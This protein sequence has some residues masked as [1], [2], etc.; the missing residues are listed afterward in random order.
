VQREQARSRRWGL[1]IAAA[2]LAA[3]VALPQT[4]GAVLSGVNG[5]IVFVSGR[6]AAA[7]NDNTS[8]LFLRPALGS[9]GAGT[10]SPVLTATGAGQHR[11]PT[12]SPDRTRIAYAEGDPG[13]MGASNFDIFILDLTNPSATPQNITNSNNVTDDRPAWSPDGTTIAF[14]SENADPGANDPP[15]QLN[16][17]LYNVG[18]GATSDFT[19]T[20]AGTYEHK[21]AWTPDSQTLFYGDGNPSTTTLNDMDILFQPV[22]GGGATQVTVEGGMSEF[23]P[24]IS[25][26]GTRMCFTRGDLGDGNARVV[27]SLTNGGGQTVL[28]GNTAAG[29]AGYNCTWSPDGTKIAYVLGVF[30]TGDLWIEDSNLSGANFLPLESTSMHFDGNP[31]WAPDGRPSCKDATV[32]TL[33]G[34]SVGVPVSCP[35]SG[36]AYEQTSVRAVL[37]TEPL[38][39]TVSPSKQDPAVL[40]PTNFTYTPNAGFIGTDQFKVRSLDEVAFGDRDGTMTVKVALPCANRTPTVVG[41]DGSDQLVGTGGKDVISALGGND[42]VKALGGNDVVCGGP[43]KDTLKGGGGKDKLLGQGGKDSLKGGGGKDTCKGGKGGDTASA[44][45]VRKS[46]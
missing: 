16:I 37:Q 10:A 9:I 33:P 29:I 20:A 28:P 14:E 38:H 25:P 34:K 8:K 40:L 5:R 26:D 39:G 23:Q 42:K 31:D 1:L 30:T 11:H 15:A 6:G 2:C 35:D 43:G 36:P 22:A 24:S 32:I 18:S 13:A 46:I 44:C 12:W 7:G 17:K 3:A 41:T 19:S 27:V 4:A 45:E 21:P